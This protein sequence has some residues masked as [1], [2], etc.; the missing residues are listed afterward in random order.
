MNLL[1]QPNYDVYNSVLY[2]IDTHFST[3]INKILWEPY[4]DLYPTYT[5]DKELRKFLEYS[6]Y[7][8]IQTQ[9]LPYHTHTYLLYTTKSILCM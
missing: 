8:S 6:L 4:K 7:K 9:D 2:G 3:S 5:C 1:N